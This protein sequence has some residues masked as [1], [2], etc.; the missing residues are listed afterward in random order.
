[1][2]ASFSLE[3]LAGAGDGE[4]RS[5]SLEALAW[6]FAPEI[7]L[8][9]T[10]EWRRHA[11]RNAPEWDPAS[12]LIVRGRIVGAIRHGL[13]YATHIAG[14]IPGIDTG[15]IRTLYGPIESRTHCF[16]VSPLD[17]GLTF[18]EPKITQA[19]QYFLSPKSVPYAA[20]HRAAAFLSAL[21]QAAGRRSRSSFTGLDAQGSIQVEAETKFDLP[22]GRR[23]FIDLMFSWADAR[24]T[25]RVVA[26]EFK[27]GH[28]VTPGQLEAYQD[29]VYGSVRRPGT[30]ARLYVV[31]KRDDKVATLNPDWN[32]VHWDAVLRRF[33]KILAE[34]APDDSDVDFRRFR[35]TVWKTVA[36]I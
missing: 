11:A 2:A 12:L 34:Y 14:E 10:S 29:H 24:G 17:W 5:G 8:L 22:E 30:D 33:E 4:W 1:M 16:R 3:R 36:G 13:A 7:V 23:R 20:R 26:V 32:V 9:N 15:A 19:R 35:R 27:I 21:E 6:R 18:S 25:R 28:H 31:L